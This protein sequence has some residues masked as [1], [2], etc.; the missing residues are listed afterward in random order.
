MLLLWLCIKKRFGV[1]L[2]LFAGRKFH[3]FPIA[4]FSSYEWYAAPFT[5]CIP[6][7]S[8]KNCGPARRKRRVLCLDKSD[9]SIV[10]ES[11]C[12]QSSK[13]NPKEDCLVQCTQD[14]VV[15]SWGEWDRKCSNTCGDTLQ[16]R[17][18]IV[19]KQPSGLGRACS[20][21]IDKQLCREPA[22]TS[23]TWSVGIWSTCKLARNGSSCGNGTRTRKIVCQPDPARE[24]ICERQTPKPT[25]TENC[26]LAC[27]GNLRLGCKTMCTRASFFL[28]MSS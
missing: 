20:S 15:S 6:H 26:S 23:F 25:Q 24:W 8:V 5:S 27:P 7:D 22:C 17:Q 3:F 16:T 28:H 10:A 18:R 1:Y 12:D 11:F 13:P 2:K 4:F 21:L 19:L 9:R 14:C